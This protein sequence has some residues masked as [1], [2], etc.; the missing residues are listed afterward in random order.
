[1]KKGKLEFIS[2][3]HDHQRCI[4]EAL[5]RAEEICA[6]RGQRFT[7]IRRKVLELIWQQHKPIGAYEV[8][9]QLQRQGRAAPPTVYRALDFLQ[10]L[11]LVHRIESLNAFVGCNQPHLPH[12]GQF[13]I[14]ESCRICAELYSDEIHSVIE[15]KASAAGFK[16][17][18]QRVEIMGLCRKCLEERSKK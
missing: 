11:G 4:A 6:N 3:E 8:L 14:C 7:A 17:R 13:L 5:A 12:E 2:S 18:Q 1:M 15:K 16:V 10:D 9:E